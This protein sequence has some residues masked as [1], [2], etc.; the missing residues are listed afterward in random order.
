MT[1]LTDWADALSRMTQD[2]LVALIDLATVE[3]TARA[4]REVY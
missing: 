4:N 2:E 1:E 3:H